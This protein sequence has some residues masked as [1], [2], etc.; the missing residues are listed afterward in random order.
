MLFLWDES[1][2]DKNDEV[3]VEDMVSATQVDKDVT[4]YRPWFFD[5]SMKNMEYDPSTT[6]SVVPRVVSI[7]DK[8]IS[9]CLLALAGGIGICKESNKVV[10]NPRPPVNRELSVYEISVMNKPNGMMDTYLGKKKDETVEAHPFA[11][12]PFMQQ[13]QQTIVGAKLKAFGTSDLAGNPHAS[14]LTT[15]GVKA[16]A[17]ALLSKTRAEQVGKLKSTADRISEMMRILKE[18]SLKYNSFKT[19]KDFAALLIQLCV[20]LGLSHQDIQSLNLWSKVHVGTAFF[21]KVAWASLGLPVLA[22][23]AGKSRMF[24]SICALMGIRPTAN[25]FQSD[26]DVKIQNDLPIVIPRPLYQDDS[27]VEIYA[28]FGDDLDE[29]F[30]QYMEILS[31]KKQNI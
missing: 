31:L 5:S 25:R 22:A 19:Y 17:G 29:D 12:L 23:V 8:G 15:A 13:P 18:A 2:N 14:P 11:F 26:F 21:I 6:Q 28:P 24:A 1:P 3:R 16:L 30:F 7:S 4:S 27:L 20:T 10:Q 9:L